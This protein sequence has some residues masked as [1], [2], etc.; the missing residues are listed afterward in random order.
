MKSTIVVYP[1]LEFDEAGVPLVEGTDLRVEQLA[2]EHLAYGWSAEE[3]SFQHPYLSLGQVH[4]AL[5]YYWDHRDELDQSIKEALEAVEA[6]AKRAGTPPF[7][8]RLR[9]RVSG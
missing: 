7:V 4:A 5:A 2:V 9:T 8:K 6:R 3:L 1:H